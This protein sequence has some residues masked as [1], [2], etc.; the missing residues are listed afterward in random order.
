MPS[1]GHLLITTARD[2][3]LGSPGPGLR[4]YSWSPNLP[5]QRW[6]HQRENCSR[7]LNQAVSTETLQGSFR[8]SFWCHCF[9]PGESAAFG[10]ESLLP[11]CSFCLIRML[12][13]HSAFG[14]GSI[15]NRCL[16]QACF[17][18][19]YVSLS[20][21]TP[22][23]LTRMKSS[24]SSSLHQ[25]MGKAGKKS[26]VMESLVEVAGPHHLYL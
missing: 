13:P 21:R 19:W 26:W 24:C 15:H 6:L 20:S 4:Q 3:T 11:S 25:S 12:V 8:Q 18:T 17:T 16:C 9:H 14:H 1:S 2:R 23:E 10:G 22:R 5:A 7:C